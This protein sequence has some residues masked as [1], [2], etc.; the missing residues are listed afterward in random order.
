MFP[1]LLLS[2]FAPKIHAVPQKRR[3]SSSSKGFWSRRLALEKTLLVALGVC[4]TVMVAGGSF[5]AFQFNSQNPKFAEGEKRNN[6]VC[7]LQNDAL[8]CNHLG[9]AETRSNGMDI[10]EEDV[11]V[12]P[13][14]TI[15]GTHNHHTLFSDHF[16]EHY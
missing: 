5:Y 11:C 10:R 16:L 1:S 6:N 4:G 2:Y 13:E 15:A 9:D 7:G 12:T 14:C 8:I 3:S